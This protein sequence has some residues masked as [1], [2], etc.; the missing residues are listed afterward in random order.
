MEL[1]FSYESCI[2]NS[3]K[4]AWRLDDVLPPDAT[5]DYGRPFL[6][7]SLSGESAIKGLS[8][9]AS[10]RLNQIS[11]YAYINLFAFVEEYIID[12]ALRQAMA[13]V[14][15]D[16]TALRALLRFSEEEVKHQELFHR[17]LALFERTFGSKVE[18]LGDAAAVAG[19][20]LSKSP[21]A[22]MLVTLH[23]EIMTQSH[24]VESVREDHRIDPL[25]SSLL[26][27]HWLEEAQHARI[28]AL[29]TMKLARQSTPQQVQQAFEEYLG[30]I[31]AFDGLLAAQAK[32]DVG[33]LDRANVGDRLDAAAI[34]AAQH[35]A[36]RNTFL[37]LGMRN[38]QFID[39][40]TQLSADGAQAVANKAAS[41]AA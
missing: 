22:V 3:E 15:G 38:R 9:Q 33:N 40:I 5:P 20:I 13:E 31:D 1:S 7:E 19:V 25:F 21:L 12:A 35:A 36:Y 23:L 18:V 10:L 41:L 16:H 4:V 24:Y 27:N 11:G 2:K 26:K 39:Y 34:E 8:E 32:M 6:P 17:V 30:L 29:E 37:V 14:H 28:D